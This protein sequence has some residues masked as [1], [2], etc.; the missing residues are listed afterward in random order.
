MVQ[1][2]ISGCFDFTT[3][4]RVSGASQMAEVDP[5]E[6]AKQI[7]AGWPCFDP[8]EM[9]ITCWLWSGWQIYLIFFQKPI[10]AYSFLN[11]CEELITSS[12]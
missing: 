12:E 4:S 10:A 8:G 1:S 9:M 6:R 5:D 11:S 7:E 3:A 2:N